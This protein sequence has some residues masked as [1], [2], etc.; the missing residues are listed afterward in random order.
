[1]AKDSPF[2]FWDGEGVRQF[3]GHS[4]GEVEI[5]FPTHCLAA[6]PETG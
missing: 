2:I 1:M 6:R 3:I 4:S 5:D